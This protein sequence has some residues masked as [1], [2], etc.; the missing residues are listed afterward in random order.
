MSKALRSLGQKRK[1]KRRTVPQKKPTKNSNNPR[2]ISRRVFRHN[3]NQNVPRKLTKVS[4]IR[5]NKFKKKNAQ[6]KGEGFNSAKR[7]F[8]NKKWQNTWNSP[9][10]EI[11]KQKNEYNQQT[12]AHHTD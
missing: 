1:R 5:E 8:R 6:G 4:A 11:F 7:S 10:T 3:R 2:N 12:Q 9:T